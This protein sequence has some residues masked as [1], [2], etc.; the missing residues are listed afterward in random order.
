MPNAPSMEHALPQRERGDDILPAG[1]ARSYTAAVVGAAVLLLT[2]GVGYRALSARL[3][4]APEQIHLT[5]G[6]LKCLPVDF[7]DWTGRDQ[8]IDEAVLKRADVD[9]HLMRFYQRGTDRATVALWIAYGIRAR[10]LMP[11]RPEVCYPGAGWSLQ[12][13]AGIDFPVPDGQAVEARL[14]TFASGTSDPRPLAV[15]TYYIVDGETCADV[16]LLRSKAWRG[17]ASIRY[18]TQIQ[19]SLR[20]ES[21]SAAA[22]ET[23]L[24]AF[25]ADSYPLIR[26]LLDS[27]VRQ[28]A[29]ERS[30][31]E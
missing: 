27:A 19:I 13:H 18:M 16:S 15:L 3:M 8:S 24:C 20:I 7:G 6:A 29:D 9:D 5:P 30:P 2:A 21:M 10:D 4:R 22:P 12:S 25:A 26:D 14:L 23:I 31:H 17:Q 1:Y 11:H 28:V